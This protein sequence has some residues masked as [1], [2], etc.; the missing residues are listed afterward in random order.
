MINS[1]LSVIEY[2]GDDDKVASRV[3]YAT[4][5]ITHVAFVTL[6]HSRVWLVP[7]SAFEINQVIVRVSAALQLAQVKFRSSIVLT[8]PAH[9]TQLTTRF[10]KA[11]PKTSTQTGEEEFRRPPSLAITRKQ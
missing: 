1:P 11:G 5:N 8:C 2:T 3:L 6:D 10:K 4:L 9:V 7:L